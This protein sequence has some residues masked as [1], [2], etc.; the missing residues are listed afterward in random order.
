MFA[1]TRTLSS[2]KNDKMNKT[3]NSSTKKVFQSSISSFELVIIVVCHIPNHS[4]RS[5][6]NIRH[7]SILIEN[8]EEFLFFGF[9]LFF[10]EVRKRLLLTSINPSHDKHNAP[11]TCIIQHSISVLFFCRRVMPYSSIPFVPASVVG[12]RQ[13]HCCTMHKHRLRVHG[14]WGGHLM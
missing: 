11:L 13:L 8:D 14:D 10:E 6:C 9:L 12:I 4:N 2:K 1:G 5:K 7:L 3:Y